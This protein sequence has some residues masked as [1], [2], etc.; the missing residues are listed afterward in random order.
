VYFVVKSPAYAVLD[1]PAED[2]EEE[3]D[4]KCYVQIGLMQE[5]RRVDK[6]TVTP[7]YGIGI[8]LFKVNCVYSFQSNQSNILA[9]L[10]QP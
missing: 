9:C 3:G 7:T 1:T 6:K 2:L 4:P 10:F 5:H 8:T